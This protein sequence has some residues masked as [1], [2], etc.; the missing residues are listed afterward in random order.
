[1]TEPSTV[2]TDAVDA[3]NEAVPSQLVGMRQS[4]SR[5]NQYSADL[6]ASMPEGQARWG[7]TTYTALAV[8]ITIW[9]ALFYRTWA[10]WGD[11]SVDAGREMYL[12][13]LLSSGKMLYRDA[14]YMA[15]PASQYF[16]S[17]L[18]RLFGVHLNVLYWA[19][20]LSALGSAL[21]LYLAGISLGS[22]VAGWTSGAVVLIQAFGRG[23]FGFPLPYSFAAVYGCLSA[24]VF[25][26]L[27]MQAMQSGEWGWL[28][29]AGT[30]AAVALLL[31]L[32][33]GM[34]CY[35]GLVL[36][37]VAESVR[38][39][40]WKPIRNWALAILPGASVCALVARW[41]ISIAGADFIT[42]ENFMTWPTSYF[43]KV[44]G[45]MWLAQTGFDLRGQVL[46]E[47][48][49]RT[50][51]F[52]GIAIGLHVLLHQ[53]RRRSGLVLASAGMGFVA[54]EYLPLSWVV[55]SAAF[56]SDR[57]WLVAVGG[58]VLLG[59]Y[60][61]LRRMRAQGTLASVTLALSIAAL[62]FQSAPIWF[63]DLAL[64]LRRMFFPRDMVLIVATVAVAGWW[65]A[66]R[67]GLNRERI[68][69]GMLLTFPVLLAF[70]ILM[71]M[72]PAGYPIYYN[73]TVI[74]A[75]LFLTPR[76]IVPSMDRYRTVVFQA[77]LVI[78]FCSLLAV[79][80]DSSALYAAQNRVTSLITERG[81]IRIPEP[82]AS[83]YAQAISFMKEK[84]AAGD[85]VLSVPEDTS[86]YF[87]SGTVCPLRVY[88]FVPGVLVPGKM[89]EGVIGEI[90]K[91]KIRYLL[92]SNRRFPEYGVPLFGTDFDIALGTY[93]RA[94]YH[95]VIPVSANRGR[96]WN[97]VI[98]ER[99]DE[100][101][102]DGKK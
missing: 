69:L 72:A 80:N 83:N 81:E 96:G 95:P 10:T 28:L 2:A 21:F 49:G 47:A 17:Y 84:A 40:S 55:R 101:N 71:G 43:M 38:M 31:K 46:L 73:G 35:G 20:S 32:E 70:R 82:T 87:L 90:E 5:L 50:L 29:G 13:A 11:L 85:S 44:Y 98:W 58:A 100:A 79:I 94:K 1:M 24:C 97:A 53:Q 88:E 75:F 15:G 92:W 34:A 61:L 45:K 41:M 36:L 74:L 59:F 66:Y 16:N 48:C 77:E 12:P 19:G 86:L 25:L 93:L 63:T 99:Q 8:L 14:W 4:I 42:Q 27:T 22:W 56:L 9:A 89:T 33:F 39:R 67:G 65:Y 3:P 78:G 57:G 6:F 54:L 51:T 52:A 102:S 18:F 26:W 37:M 76:F 68:A 30:A 62:V 64:S 23:L 60:L 7:L 91:R